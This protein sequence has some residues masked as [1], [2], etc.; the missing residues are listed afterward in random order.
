MLPTIVDP[1]SIKAS[2]K[3]VVLEIKLK[4]KETVKPKGEPIKLKRRF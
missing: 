4:R 3:N 2:Y 1:K